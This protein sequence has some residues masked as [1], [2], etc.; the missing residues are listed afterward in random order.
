LIAPSIWWCAFVVLAVSGNGEDDQDQEEAEDLRVLLGSGVMSAHHA[1][2]ACSSS[3][4][5]CVARIATAN[6]HA[7]D[8]D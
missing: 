4:A 2:L 7:S 5:I 6:D 3:G 8:A 1:Q